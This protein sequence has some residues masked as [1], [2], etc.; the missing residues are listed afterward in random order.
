M[1]EIQTPSKIQSPDNENNDKDFLKRAAIVAG[2]S[3][4]FGGIAT[5]GIAEAGHRD[6]IKNGLIADV[7]AKAEAYNNA[8]EAAV[9]TQYDQKDVVAEIDVLTDSNLI[10]PAQ[11]A[12]ESL[13]SGETVEPRVYEALLDSARQHQ[14]QPGEKYSIVPVDIDPQQQNGTEYIVVDSEH[15]L[16]TDLDTLPAPTFESAPSDTNK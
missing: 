15:V 4:A 7:Q 1:S 9:N 14:P 3:L 10:D 2:A 6:D 13:N 8:V 16:N 12:I 5:A 11:S